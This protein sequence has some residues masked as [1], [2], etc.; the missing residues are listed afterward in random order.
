MCSGDGF[1]F[2][3]NWESA[4]VLLELHGIVSVAFDSL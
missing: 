2:N 3:L 4:T 1:S